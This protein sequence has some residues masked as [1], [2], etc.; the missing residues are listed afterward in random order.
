MPCACFRLPSVTP[1]KVIDRW[2][3]NSQPNVYSTNFNQYQ[4][5]PPYQSSQPVVDN[6]ISNNLKNDPSTPITSPILMNQP[7][8][9]KSEDKKVEYDDWY[10][11]GVIKPAENN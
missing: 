3:E 4:A 10:Y 5:P 2:N 11:S 9:N 6:L 1:S 7:F 8:T